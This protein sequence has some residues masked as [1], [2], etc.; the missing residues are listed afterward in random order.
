MDETFTNTKR[1]VSETIDL[2]KI[3]EMYVGWQKECIARF[4]GIQVKVD[5]TLEGNQYY[6]AVSRELYY[7]MERENNGQT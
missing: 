5:E 1:A 2:D 6:I 4:Q 7:Q 3:T